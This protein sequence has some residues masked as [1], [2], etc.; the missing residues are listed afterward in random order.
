MKIKAY[1]FFDKSIAHASIR[2]QEIVN[3]EAISGNVFEVLPDGSI[4]DAG[5]YIWTMLSG[6]IEHENLDT[7]AV[8]LMERGW[9]TADKGWHP[10][11]VYKINHVEASELICINHKNHGEVP[12]TIKVHHLKD[13]DTA[14]FKKGSKLFVADGRIVIDGKEFWGGRQI[15][16]LTDKQI[17]CAE[18]SIIIELV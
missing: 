14:S 12:P 5:W 1:P 9:S 10:A 16:L 18:S 4:A 17:V 3:D 2:K 13:S 7:G 11:G 8:I 6:K 15:S